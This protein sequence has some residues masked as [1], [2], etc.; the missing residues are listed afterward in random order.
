MKQVRVV[1]FASALALAL[2]GCSKSN[3]P[4]SSSDN[5]T[6]SDG[7]ISIYNDETYLN[8]DLTTSDDSVGVDTTAGLAKT[9]KTLAF[10]M[11][12]VA[13]ISPP[14]VSKQKVQATSVSLNGTYAYVSYNFAGDPYLGAI[15]VVSVNGKSTKTVSRA[16]YTDTDV[17]SVFYYNNNVYMAEATGNASYLPPAI[18]EKIKITSGKLSLT[19]NIRRQLASFAG[20]SIAAGNGVVYEV[21]GNAGGLYTLS[22]DS[23]KVLSYAPLSDARWVDFSASN[24]IV[25]QGTPGRISVFNVG[26]MSA[27]LNT[28]NFPGADIAQ[29]KSTVQ[30][31]GGKALIAAGDSGVKLMNLATGKIVGSIPRLIVSGLSPSVTVTNAVAGAGQYIYISDGE[32][33]V[34]VAKASQALENLSG[35]APITLTVLGQLKFS[36]LQSVNHVAFNGSTLVVASGSGGVRIVTV[37]F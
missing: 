33:G 16:T 8:T 34:Y 37:T 22:T 13:T 10:S 19:G 9:S 17:S 29:S 23:L 5:P 27:P 30:L 11:K 31:I 28:Y 14:T 4:V 26:S 7:R 35:D 25:A 18:A 2:F 20:T 12:L 21:T 3:N 32:A 24:V 36:K 6:E 15:D 1:M